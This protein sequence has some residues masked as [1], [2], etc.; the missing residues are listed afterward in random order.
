MHWVSPSGKDFATDTLERRLWDAAD[1]F[2]ANSSL[3]A[4]QY[5]QPILGLIF[6]RFPEV[7]F[8]ISGQRP[9]SGDECWPKP[10]AV[11]AFVYS[12]QTALKLS[13]ARG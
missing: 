4:D 5:S 10:P 2:R 9:V 3:S 7:R 6:L 13:A 8:I 1:Q 12:V 11:R